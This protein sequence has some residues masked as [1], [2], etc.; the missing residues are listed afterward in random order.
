MKYSNISHSCCLLLRF[1]IEIMQSPKK[2]RK[3]IPHKQEEKGSAFS[4][5]LNNF[6]DNLGKTITLFNIHL[7][8]FYL[9]KDIMKHIHSASEKKWSSA[10]KYCADL[11]YYM[12]FYRARMT[13]N[14]I[15]SDFQVDNEILQNHNTDVLN[16][17]CTCN[18]K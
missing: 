1:L 9:R 7:F 12:L 2:Q 17:N 13:M 18:Y 6:V 8:K 14:S 10:K 15:T 16:E 4:C 5:L 11:Q 3:T